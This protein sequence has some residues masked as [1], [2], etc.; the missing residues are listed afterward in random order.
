[1]QYSFESND[2]FFKHVYETVVEGGVKNLDSMSKTEARTTLGLESSAESAPEKA[3]IKQAYKKLAFQ[4]HPDRFEGT[5]EECEE[6]AHRFGRVK[7]AYETLSSGVRESGSSWY[8]SL[9][10][11]ARTEFV[12]PVNLLP[13][14]A[15]QEQMERKRA[16]GALLGLDQNLIQSFV[17]R[18]LRSE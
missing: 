8:E 1:M 5:S 17:A 7:L 4:L 18:N 16:K 3:D 15:A 12:G 6:A 11:R 2:S 14:A 13:L 9:G 10:G